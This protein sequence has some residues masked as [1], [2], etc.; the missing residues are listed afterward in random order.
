MSTAVVRTRRL[1][2]RS[3]DQAERHRGAFALMNADPEVMADYGRTLTTA[4]SDRKFDR[5]AAAQREHGIARMVVE[6]FRGRFLGYIGPMRFADGDHPLGRHDEIGWRLVRRAWGHGYATE[7]ALAAIAH[8]RSVGI[9]GEIVAYTSSDNA[10]SQAVM[11]R[12]GLLRDPTR[13]FDLTDDGRRWHCLL[14]AT[15]P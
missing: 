8:A 2:L 9:V 7:G 13:D 6:D 5:Y 14:W 12:V 11:R 10:R 15:R 1:V 3:W 4:E